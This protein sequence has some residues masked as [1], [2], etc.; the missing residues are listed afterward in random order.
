MNGKSAAAEARARAAWRAAEGIHF[1]RE[2]QA[3][4]Q[5]TSFP[6]HHTPW[7]RHVYL[8]FKRYEATGDSWGTIL[9][10]Q[11]F[12][13]SCIYRLSRAAVTGARPA[14]LRKPLRVVT[15]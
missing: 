12:W 11:G 6:L 2:P 14:F 9:L 8:D 3:A 5:V 7:W 13:A 15:V 10:S 4:P 1:G